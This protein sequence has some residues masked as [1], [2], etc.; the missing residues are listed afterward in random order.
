M[1]RSLYFVG[2]LLAMAL[3]VFAQGIELSPTR[4]PDVATPA[5]AAAP[6]APTASDPAATALDDLAGWPIAAG[7]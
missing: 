1:T 7:R 6:A 2:G 4:Q 3:I 5:R